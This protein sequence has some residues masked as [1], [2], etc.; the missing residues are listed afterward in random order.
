GADMEVLR[1]RA[2]EIQAAM[3]SV[4]GVVDLN[5]EQQ[6]GEP[7]VAVR[8]NRQAMA[9]YGINSR[10]LAE[11]IRTAFFGSEVSN[12]FDQQRT[13]AIVVRYDPDRAKGLQSIRDTLI[14]TPTGAKIP[15]S[16]VADVAMS[17]GP[18]VINREDAQRRI[19]ITCDVEGT[20]LTGVA[21]SIT[22]K[23]SQSLQL[24]TGYYVTYGGQYEARQAAIREMLLLGAAAFAGIFL[25]LF[26]AFRS[27]RQSLL[28][29]ANLPLALVG[30][31]AAVLL[32]SGG[33]TSVASLVGFIT[34]FGIATRNGIMLITHYSHLMAEEGIEFGRDLVRRGAMERLSPILMTALT[35]GLALLPLA[36]SAGRPGRELEQPISVVILGG[37]VTSTLLN[38]VVL[39]ALYLRFG[40]P[41][42]SEALERTAV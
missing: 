24:P 19:L 4:P 9:Q 27:V 40:R 17:S 6:T 11:T 37:L 35:A 36:L 29:M 30:G 26:L 33:E 5:V 3:S 16:A 25:L 12:V 13:F 14:D 22:K 8:F 1:K 20:S 39:P 2:A 15:L 21:E 41:G 7:K 31:V 34:L 18:A 23:I 32:A 28:V 42:N 38:M 10:D